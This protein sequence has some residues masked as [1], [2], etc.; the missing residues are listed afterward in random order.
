MVAIRDAGIILC[1]LCTQ[2]GATANPID[3]PDRE[4]GLIGPG[5]FFG[6]AATTTP[7]THLGATR[8]APHVPPLARSMF[9]VTLDWVLA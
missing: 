2:D 4:T 1:G 9:F 5:R 8:R 3:I 7:G 6:S